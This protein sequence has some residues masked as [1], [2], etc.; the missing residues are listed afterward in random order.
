MP[1][2]TAYRELWG[3]QQVLPVLCS[4]LGVPSCP[5]GSVSA[6]LRPLGLRPTASF[7]TWRRGAGLGAGLR[8][9]LD[10]TDFGYGLGELEQL[11]G[12]PED[13]PAARDTV[14]GLCRALG[15]CPLGA[16]DCGS[17]PTSHRPDTIL[18][19]FFLPLLTFCIFLSLILQPPSPATP[20][21][22]PGWR[23]GERLEPQ[24]RKG[25]KDRQ[26]QTDGPELHNLPGRALS[27]ALKTF[28]LNTDSQ[29]LREQHTPDK[30]TSQTSMQ[31]PLKRCKLNSVVTS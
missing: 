5:W 29:A 18:C 17:L 23:T 13:V 12:T 22:V 25:G 20:S 14:E 27:R 28:Q 7:V 3:D 10:Q 15:P 24:Q 16:T 11:V 4:I 9:E 30:G 1:P 26:T 31:L 6:A 21:P 19:C 2:S 8:V